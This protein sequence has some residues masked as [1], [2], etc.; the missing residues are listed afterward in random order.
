MGKPK[1]PEKPKPD[2]APISELEKAMR[3]LVGVPKVELEAQEQKY[4]RH[5]ANKPKT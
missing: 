3:G 2:A 5:R 1:P 4:R